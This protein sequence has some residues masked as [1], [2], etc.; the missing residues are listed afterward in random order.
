M[1]TPGKTIPVALTIL[2]S[3]NII[4]NL[5]GAIIVGLS[6]FNT[7]IWTDIISNLDESEE[8]RRDSIETAT[9]ITMFLSSLVGIIFFIFHNYTKKIKNYYNG[10]IISYGVILIAFITLTALQFYYYQNV[11]NILSDIS[12]DDVYQFT[13]WW[14]LASLIMTIAVIFALFRFRNLV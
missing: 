1:T 12:G 8:E 13:R 6:S 3:L 14:P 11:N 9:I 4:Y 7:S 10:F 5:V 2:T